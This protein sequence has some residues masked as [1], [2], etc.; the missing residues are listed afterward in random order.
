MFVETTKV[1]RLHLMAVA[2]EVYGVPTEIVG[3]DIIS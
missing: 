3:E 1:F 2:N